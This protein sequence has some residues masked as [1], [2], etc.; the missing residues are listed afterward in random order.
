MQVKH[1]SPMDFQQIGQILTQSPKENNG[2]QKWEFSFA[3]AAEIAQYQVSGPVVLDYVSGMSLLVIYRNNQPTIFYLDRVVSLYPGTLFSIVPLGEK[4]CVHLFATTAQEPE[5]VDFVPADI[6]ENN[7]KSLHFEKIY[8]F[9]YQEC[10]HNFYFRG[11]KHLPYELVYVDRGRMHN[12]VGGQDILLDQQ[13]IMIIDSND[14]HMQYSDVSVSF[15]TVSFWLTDT[16]L[17]SITNKAIKLTPKLKSILKK[18]LSQ[19]QVG[20][21]GDDY[22]S[23]LLKI[24]LIEL[25]QSSAPAVTSPIPSESESENQIVDR[26]IRII[27]QNVQKKLTLDELAA[28]IHISVPY[29]YKL[30]QEYLGTSPGKYIARIRIEECKMLLREGRLSMGQIASDM[31]FSSLQHFS[32]QFH[33]ICGMTPSQYVRSLR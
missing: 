1:L 27:S 10:T 20:P 7:A 32:R 26:A 6:L 4:C 16:G 13:D 18:M 28:Q 24:L 22:I 30:F 33:T 8:T 12:L 5:P 9:L 21:Y 17:S 23:S 2:Y 11:E 25:L 19:S 3:T 31:G 29:L 14:W 15:L